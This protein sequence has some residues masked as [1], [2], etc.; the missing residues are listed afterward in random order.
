MKAWVFLAWD[1]HK[2]RPALVWTTG[3]ADRPEPGPATLQSLEAG[4][5]APRS[6]Y[7][8]ASYGRA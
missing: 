2:K 5:S 8:L 4:C 1:G 6:S 3:T 7:R